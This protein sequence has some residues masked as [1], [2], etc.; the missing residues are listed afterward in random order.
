MTATTP[1]SRESISFRPTTDEDSPFLRDLYAST[2]AE[3]MN[4]VPWPGEQKEVFLTMQYRAQAAHYEKYYPDCEFSIIEWN[5]R[6]VGRLY[7]HRQDDDIRIVDIALIPEVRGQ[8][9]GGLL[10]AE[11]L[12]EGKATNRQVSIHVEHYNPAM[13]LYERLGFQH[14]D[15]NG[16][17]HL[18]VWKPGA[19]A[20]AT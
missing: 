15:T 16:V 1:I 3:E 11:I 20:G 13:K 2:R 8:G 6:A 18:M 17:Y 14:V 12:D 5:G 19:G 10:L 7:V 4:L 9:I